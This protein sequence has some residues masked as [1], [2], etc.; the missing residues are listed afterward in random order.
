[1]GRYGEQSACKKNPVFPLPSAFPQHY[2]VGQEADER[3]KRGRSTPVTDQDEPEI[4]EQCRVYTLPQPIVELARD[5]RP[6]CRHER[7]FKPLP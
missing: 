6:E 5:M 1:M 2:C 3:R 7:I 4:I